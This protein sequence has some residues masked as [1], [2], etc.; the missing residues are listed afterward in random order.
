[1]GNHCLT[2]V[3][4]TIAKPLIPTRSRVRN[5]V[6]SSTS[7]KKGNFCQKGEGGFGGHVILFDKSWRRFLLEG[8]GGSGDKRSLNDKSFL[9]SETL[10]F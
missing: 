6:K 10:N 7:P 3:L 9:F 4:Y 2:E 8:E 5:H 1:M